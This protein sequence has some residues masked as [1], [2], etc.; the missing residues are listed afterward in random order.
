MKDSGALTSPLGHSFTGGGEIEC[1]EGGRQGN[2]PRT[3]AAQFGRVKWLQK[4]NCRNVSFFK[5]GM[6]KGG[7][8]A[9]KPPKMNQEKKCYNLLECVKDLTWGGEK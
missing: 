5:W 6:N 7:M 1:S 8:E 4:R 3:P 9:I 2:G